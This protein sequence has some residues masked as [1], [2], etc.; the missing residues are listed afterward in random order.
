MERECAHR[1]FVAVEASG[2]KRVSFAA[3]RLD[4]KIALESTHRHHST[5]HVLVLRS[6]VAA[7]EMRFPLL[8]VSGASEQSLAVRVSSGEELNAC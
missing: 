7:G 8:F 5:S 1:C 2:F 4:K 3:N 6:F